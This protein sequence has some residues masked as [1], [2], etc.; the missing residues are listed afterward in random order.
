MVSRRLYRQ[1]YLD[2]S[3][4]ML[5]YSPSKFATRALMDVLFPFQ[6]YLLSQ[7]QE[8]IE[9]K[10]TESLILKGYISALLRAHHHQDHHAYSRE[11]C[12]SRSDGIAAGNS[13]R[14]F[15][16][17]C[18]EY[19]LSGKLFFRSDGVASFGNRRIGSSL[20]QVA[21]HLPNSSTVGL[22]PSFLGRSFLG[23]PVLW[24]AASLQPP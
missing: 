12:G 5:S 3:H 9:T 15:S 8:D 17:L 11:R 1:S 10:R 6:V 21:D 19:A 13:N 20:V 22:L 14:C 24:M 23:P 7:S 4:H 16:P 18:Y 2:S